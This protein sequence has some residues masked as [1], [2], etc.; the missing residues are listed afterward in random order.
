MI[1][2]NTFFF[3]LLFLFPLKMDAQKNILQ[4]I[5]NENKT[6]FG[7][8]LSNLDK[9][10]VQ[11]IYTQINRDENNTPHF[12]SY[13]FNVD[14]KRY[15]YPASTIK[16]PIAF[17]AME[18][19]NNLNIIDLNKYSTMKNGAG[20]EPQSIAMVDT[21]SATALPSVA[22]YVKKIFLVSDNDANNRL[23][24]FLGQD[25]I[26][27]KLWEKGYGNVSL[28]HR[29]GIGGFDTEA[30]RHTNPVYFYN[31]KNEL[32]YFQ[33]EV[34]SKVMREFNLKNSL[35]GKGYY[36]GGELINQPFDFSKKNYISLQDQHDILKAVT[37]PK[38]V[39]PNQRFNLTQKDY[40][41]LYQV[42]SERPRE[43]K[44]PNYDK[45]DHYVK[46][47]IYGDQKDGEHIPPNIRIFNKVGWA[48]GFLTDISY[49]V[50]FDAGVEFFLAATIH[51]NED[52]IYNDDNYEYETIGLP[53]LSKLG[54]VVYEYEK[55][56]DKKHAPD[57]SRFKIEK[58]D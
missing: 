58:Y 42:M 1:N 28:V 46:F 41:F 50:D 35:R 38:S 15:Y 13:E 29:L 25:Y 49:I 44:Y 5:L 54:S 21:T 14:E 34:Y 43:S 19:I 6:Q 18:K 39:P 33:G 2:K 52:G 10:E 12:T 26:N 3:L 51:V 53:F 36:S 57:L 11:I 37:F 8:V 20:S 45:P 27:K 47:F 31:D 17:L 48:Y 9:H 24:E 30:N 23:Y 40:R 32:L 56:R 7:N 16:M 22:H 55:K 4:K